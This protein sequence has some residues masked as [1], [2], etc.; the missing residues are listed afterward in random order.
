M[1]G[2]ARAVDAVV[3]WP[4][5]GAPFGGVLPPCSQGATHAPPQAVTADNGSAAAHQSGPRAQRW[6]CAPRGTARARRVKREGRADAAMRTG[7]CGPTAFGPRPLGGFSRCN[8]SALKVPR[9]LTSLRYARSSSFG[10]TPVARASWA[11]RSRSS[12]S[13]LISASESARLAPAE[14]LIGG[15]GDEN[16]IWGGMEWSGCSAK[17]FMKGEGGHKYTSARRGRMSKPL[18]HGD[19]AGRRRPA[20]RPWRRAAAPRLWAA[21]QTAPTRR[22]LGAAGKVTA[23]PRHAMCG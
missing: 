23:C 14:P 7:S 1:Q 20:Y 16:V 6:V 10:G 12:C 18:A 4:S 13:K 17:S 21:R 19:R 22:P 2:A 11:S 15:E 9:S 3:R 5:L 8:R